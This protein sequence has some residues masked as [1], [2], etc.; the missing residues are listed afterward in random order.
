[1]LQMIVQYITQGFV[2]QIM[3]K[4]KALCNDDPMSSKMQKN[5]QNQIKLG[6]KGLSLIK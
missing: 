3:F 1:M 5:D 6:R 2:R 4:V